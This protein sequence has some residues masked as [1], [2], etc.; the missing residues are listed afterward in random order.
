MPDVAPVPE[1]LHTVTPRLVVEDARAAI[2]FYGR[3][4]GGVALGEPFTMPDGKVA[5]AETRLGDSVVYLVEPVD[6]GEGAAPS[7]LGG[8]VTAIMAVTVPDVDALWARALA[9]G[10]G[11]R[12]AR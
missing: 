10:C 5:H 8:Q 1:G 4:F 12:A 3:A 6:G 7:S 9:A 11:L 2:D